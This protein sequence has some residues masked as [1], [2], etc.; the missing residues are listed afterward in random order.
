MSNLPM[1]LR[2][3]VTAWRAGRTAAQLRGAPGETLMFQNFAYRIT[4]Q[5]GLEGM[6]LVVLV[7]IVGAGER[8]L[9]EARM[10]ITDA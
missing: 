2:A 7:E 4:P 1:T 9:G 10:E 3:A 8:V 5:P 6:P